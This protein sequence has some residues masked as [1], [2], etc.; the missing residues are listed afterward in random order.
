MTILADRVVG[1]CSPTEY[2]GLELDEGSTGDSAF[3][4]PTLV[5]EFDPGFSVG[6]DDGYSVLH[7]ATRYAGSF[8]HDDVPPATLYG[9]SL[10]DPVTASAV[11]RPM[12]HT[13]IGVP[14][15]HRLP[16]SAGVPHTERFF[17]GF[18]EAPMSLRGD[19]AEVTT[20]AVADLLDML[21]EPSDSTR[22]NFL[23]PAAGVL[24]SWSRASWEGPLQT[25][26]VT[27]VAEVLTRDI[28]RPISHK[29]WLTVAR[30]AT[31]SGVRE[32]VLEHLADLMNTP[33]TRRAPWATWPVISAF[34]D[35]MAFVRAWPRE[36]LVMPDVG[37]A[38]DGEVNFLWKGVDLHVDL[39]FYG[40]GTFSY[41]AKDGDG[42]E[43]A[44][45]DVAATVGLPEDLLAI[46]KA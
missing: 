7:P 42:E 34:E 19:A 23:A 28:S 9:R 12:V 27:N 10:T 44:D 40:D 17:G 15:V 4:P 29:V 32:L 1:L 35:A 37:L 8:V 21:T 14:V 6:D 31:R 13:V 46:L 25:H 2:T 39:G 3:T 36:A 11:P 16:P 22:R 41:Y 33:K 43:Y 45:D 26:D 20:I 30:R 5:T 18:A 24:Q 38:D